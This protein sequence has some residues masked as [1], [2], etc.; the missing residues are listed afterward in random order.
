M[1]NFPMKIRG[2]YAIECQEGEYFIRLD[3]LRL[4]VTKD[5]VMR[6][7]SDRL[8]EHMLVFTCNPG[9]GDTFY[10]ELYPPWAIVGYPRGMVGGNIYFTTRAEA[11]AYKKS[12]LEDKIRDLS[13]MSYVYEKEL[14]EM[15]SA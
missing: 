4:Q 3:G 13:E 7:L 8:P 14:K 6:M 15:Q 9:P 12:L 1:V 2:E 10:N 5:Q 11:E